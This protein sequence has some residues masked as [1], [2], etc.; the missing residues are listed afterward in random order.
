MPHPT[1]T[2]SYRP[3]DHRKREIRLLVVLKRGWRS[4]ILP[5][6]ELV[7]NCRLEHATFG[8][9]K[10]IKSYEALSYTW[11]RP[12]THFPPRFIILNGAKFE[13]GENLY[14]ALQYLAFNSQDRVLWVDAICINQNDAS[15]KNHQVQQMGDIYRMASQVVVW[16]GLSSAGTKR[17]FKF[18]NQHNPYEDSPDKSIFVISLRGDAKER[19]KMSTVDQLKDLCERDYWSRVWIIQEIGLAS[20]LQVVCG[21]YQFPWD[22]LDRVLKVVGPYMPTLV[23]SLGWLQP[24]PQGD[25]VTLQSLLSKFETSLCKVP[26]DKI[27]GFSGLAS[28]WAEAGI[29][30]DYN[31]SLLCLHGDVLSFYSDRAFQSGAYSFGAD[32]HRQ[33]ETRTGRSRHSEVTHPMFHF[34]GTQAR[35]EPFM[36]CSREFYSN[37]LQLSWLIWNQLAFSRPD[38][39]LAMQIFPIANGTAGSIDETMFHKVSEAVQRTFVKVGVNEILPF[40]LFLLTKSELHWVSS[41]LQSLYSNFTKTGPAADFSYFYRLKKYECDLELI[42]ERIGGPQK[43]PRR[44]TWTVRRGEAVIPYAFDTRDKTHVFNTRD[45]TTEIQG[46][47]FWTT[48]F[49]LSPKVRYEP[50]RYGDFQ[51]GWFC[52]RK[53]SNAAPA[54]HR[55]SEARSVPGDLGFDRQK[56][57]DW[58]SSESGIGYSLVLPRHQLQLCLTKEVFKMCCIRHTEGGFF[59]DQLKY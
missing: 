45:E 16:L 5:V 41:C 57:D 4:K 7:P 3:L 9:S 30:I 39:V 51:Q 48:K 53:H 17:V 28:D 37:L 27:Y 56:L 42:M 54:T 59:S 29:P 14:H 21:K 24:R 31:K 47:L 18:I 13:V 26:H 52:F 43:P 36:R 19:W 49:Y 38:L 35:V 2:F 50:V 46:E 33:S 34:R 10:G 8:R 23:A 15:E 12:N 11:G 55:R 44:A 1:D 58:A 6:D 25:S 20:K 40:W 22:S 32:Q